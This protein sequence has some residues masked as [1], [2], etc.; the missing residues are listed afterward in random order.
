M[1]KT[2]IDNEIVK[3]KSNIIDG[4]GT[5]II[6]KIIIIK[7]TIVKSFDFTIVDKNGANL[8]ATL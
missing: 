2:A 1:I 3:K 5:M 6:A 7:K 8:F 4:N